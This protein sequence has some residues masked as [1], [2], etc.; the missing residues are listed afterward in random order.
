VIVKDYATAKNSGVPAPAN[1]PV[2]FSELSPEVQSEMEF[3]CFAA[4]AKGRFQFEECIKAKLL[5]NQ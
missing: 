2:V 1:K 3:L 5:T 4:K